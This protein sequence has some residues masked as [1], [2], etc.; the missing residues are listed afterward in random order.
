MNKVIKRGIYGA[1][2]GLAGT[3]V[4]DQVMGA[5][6]KLQPEKDKNLEKRLIREDPHEKLV[7]TVVEDSLGVKL[8]RDTRST[9]GE[10]V[11]WGYGIA[12]GAAYG[13][14]RNEFPAIS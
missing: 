2:A 8:A 5:L 10:A 1:I 9:L 11:H 4:I 6:S 13:I 3:I 14:L 12:W 7:R